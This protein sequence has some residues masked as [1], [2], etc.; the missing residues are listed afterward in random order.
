M[1]SLCDHIDFMGRVNKWVNK[2]CSLGLAIKMWISSNQLWWSFGK[3]WTLKN[4]F[5]R[6]ISLCV[7]R[8]GLF[9]DLCIYNDIFHL[10]CYGTHCILTF[11][12]SKLVV[13]MSDSIPNLHF[14]SYVIFSTFVS[15]SPG[16]LSLPL[17]CSPSS[18]PRDDTW[19]VASH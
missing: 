6:Q 4:N 12:N 18:L 9:C 2:C 10:L 7:V 14:S 17:L 11:I 5:Q 19:P 13:Y 15:S 8:K 16:S 3:M 1:T